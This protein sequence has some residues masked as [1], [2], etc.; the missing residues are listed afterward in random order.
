[1]LWHCGL[2]QDGGICIWQIGTRWDHRS[3]KE[4]SHFWIWEFVAGSKRHKNHCVMHASPKSLWTRR[5]FAI[6]SSMQSTTSWI[7]CLG[8]CSWVPGLRDLNRDEEGRR[9]RRRRRRADRSLLLGWWSSIICTA[10]DLLSQALRNAKALYANYARWCGTGVAKLRSITGE[11]ISFPL[12][13]K[14]GLDL[15]CSRFEVPHCGGCLRGLTT[16]DQCFTW[17][18]LAWELVLVIWWYEGKMYFWSM[19]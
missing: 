9:R 14:S 2:N 16:G 13:S 7:L 3:R 4:G 12:W 15:L 6:G 11:A 18:L 17:L 8:G 1:M 19:G 10:W 5:L